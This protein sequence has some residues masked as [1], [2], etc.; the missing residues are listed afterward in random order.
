MRRQP[1]THGR[2]REGKGEKKL[3]GVSFATVGKR[4]RSRNA[5]THHTGRPVLHIST[6]SFIAQAV[7]K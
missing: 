4:N 6:S 7:E 3:S 2:E 5:Q 1:A